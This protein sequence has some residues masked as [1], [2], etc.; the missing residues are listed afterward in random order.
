[1]NIDEQSF[2]LLVDDN[3]KN[4]QVLGSLLKDHYRTAVA[5]SGPEALKFADKKQPNL[6]LLDV[7]MPEMDGF[8]VCGKL[9]SSPRTMDI[10]VIFLTARTE[11]EDVIKG[12]QLGA[13]DYVTKPF[14]KDELLVRVRTQLK[15]KHSEDALKQALHNYKIARESAEEA[16]A[17]IMGSIRYAQMI[18]RSL[19]PNLETV[20]SWLPSSFFIWSPRDIVGGD[21]FLCAPL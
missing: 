12:F 16:N 20:K 17:K 13:V 1:M 10:P 3:P 2:V 18:Q 4:L 19:P 21:I 8:E 14:R 15:I 7:M 11:T 6:I 9:K 5:T